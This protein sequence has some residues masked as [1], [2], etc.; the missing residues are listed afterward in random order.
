[1][2]SKS[3]R[4]ALEPAPLT[5]SRYGALR[6]EVPEENIQGDIDRA[7][8]HFMEDFGITASRGER[9]QATSR[10]CW[11]HEEEEYI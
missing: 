7:D 4:H 9:L 8:A 6:D 5:E 11:H 1:M 10:S 2:H 3:P